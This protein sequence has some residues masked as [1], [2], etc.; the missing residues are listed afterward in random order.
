MAKPQVSVDGWRTVSIPLGQGKPLKL[1]LHGTNESTET[2]LV[3]RKCWKMGE[4]S[5][6]AKSGSRGRAER[7]QKGR[8]MAKQRKLAKRPDLLGGRRG[9]QRKRKNKLFEAGSKKEITKGSGGV[10]DQG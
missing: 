8:K 5:E 10:Q 9:G 7:V 4:M 2:E 3:P 6:M 1:S